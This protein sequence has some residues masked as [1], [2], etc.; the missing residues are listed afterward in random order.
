MPEGYSSAIFQHSYE[1]PFSTY[2]KE[3]NLRKPFTQEGFTTQT[4]S[5]DVD[6]Y[7]KLNALVQK[8]SDIS[9]NLD[10]YYELRN[11]LSASS[12]PE[13]S[14]N[15]NKYNDFAGNQLDYNRT[16]DVQDAAREDID[17]MI[18]QQNNVY[19]LGM[20]TVTT[21]LITSYMFVR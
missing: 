14:G 15:Y 5:S 17:T 8:R 9:G 19:I 12:N 3:G 6:Q 20:I 13:D 4:F 7:N 18:I 1:K 2:R 10:E 21:L 16:E 11:E